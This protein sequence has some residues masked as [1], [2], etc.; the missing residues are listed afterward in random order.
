M[1]VRFKEFRGA[2]KTWDS[3]YIEASD[4]ATGIGRE[5]L[6]SISQAVHAVPVVT[7]WYWG[8]QDHN[9]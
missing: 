8:K 2:F 4:F 9:P 3:L 1:T 6:I 5:N 7:V